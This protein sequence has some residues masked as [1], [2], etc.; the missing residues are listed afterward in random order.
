VPVR[1]RKGTNDATLDFRRW[2]PGKI[3]GGY[4]A[5]ARPLCLNH[6]PAVP[7]GYKDTVTYWP[8]SYGAQVRDAADCM[9]E[10]S[11]KDLQCVVAQAK[12]ADKKRLLEQ[13]ATAGARMPTLVHPSV[14]IASSVKVGDGCIIN[15]NAVIQPLAT[16][17]RGA[18]IHAQV[19][20]DHDATIGD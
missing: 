13:R 15:A 7:K 1:S 3:R 12:P 6:N 8:N 20:I 11:A 2:R 10:C 18:M 16:V 9:S 5:L 14:V 4:G 19:S 17:G